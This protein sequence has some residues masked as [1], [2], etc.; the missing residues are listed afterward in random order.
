MAFV[1]EYFIHVHGE[2]KG[3]YTLSQLK[4]LYDKGFVVEETLYWHDGMEQWLPVSQVCGPPLRTRTK[5][6]RETQFLV[7]TVLLLSTVVIA[8]FAP[9]VREGWKE[10]NQHE[11]T[12]QSAYWAARGYLRE[13]LKKSKTT[14]AFDKKGVRTAGL[15]SNGAEATATLEC[16]VF[17]PHQPSRR[18]TW[19]VSVRFNPA[20]QEWLGVAAEEIPSK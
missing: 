14:V 3:P 20:R 18:A 15:S 6:R 1:E 4:H 13:E 2:Q 9:V 8:Y 12:R 16:T 11:F 5:Q 7:G 19:Q 17:A 10:A